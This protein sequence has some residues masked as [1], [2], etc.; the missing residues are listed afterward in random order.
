MMFKSGK[1]DRGLREN[2]SKLT[3]KL[4]QTRLSYGIFSRVMVFPWILPA[5]WLAA[6]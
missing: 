5:R 3:L 4:V 1:S 2:Y 6:I